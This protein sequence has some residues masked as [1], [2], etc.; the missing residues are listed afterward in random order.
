MRQGAAES[1][2][3]VAVLRIEQE[4]LRRMR[5]KLLQFSFLNKGPDQKYR[6]Q[7][8]HHLMREELEG[9]VAFYRTKIFICFKDSVG[10]DII[11]KT[12]YVKKGPVG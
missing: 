12:C 7:R 6:V 11:L 3:C 10:K 5:Q 8:R 4:C 9:H 1:V 2:L